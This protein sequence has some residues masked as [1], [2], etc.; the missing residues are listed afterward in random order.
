M[1]KLS[2]GSLRWDVR[3]VGVMTRSR[4]LVTHPM[5]D[6]GKL[7]FVREGDGFGVSTFDGS[8]ICAFDSVVQRV[9]LGDAPGLEMSLPPADM[10]RRETVRHARRAIV[11]LPCSVRY[12]SGEHQLRAGFTGDLSE[13]GAQVAIER[14]LPPGVDAVDL[15]LR[16]NVLGEQTT[17]QVRAEIRS[18][19]DD[20]RPEVIATLLGLQFAGIDN[21]ARLSL[22]HFV[23][24][25]LLADAD[26]L[27]AVIR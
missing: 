11:T 15:S 8:V 20:P 18:Q 1:L 3:L 21:L 25:K 19:A 17:L 12:G 26:D 24:E 23:R 7:V 27:F 14:P 10:R 5:T 22:G 2:S 4:F 6:E 16:L 13:S 9:A